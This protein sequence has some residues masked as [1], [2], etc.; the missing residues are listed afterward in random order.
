[1]LFIAFKSNKNDVCEKGLIEE[2]EGLKGLY[3]KH[4]SLP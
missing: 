3:A 1:M 2:E 4:K